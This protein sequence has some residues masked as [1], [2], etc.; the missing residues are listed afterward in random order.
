MCKSP[1]VRLASSKYRVELSRLLM[2][3]WI[4]AHGMAVYR[5]SNFQPWVPALASALPPV[6]KSPSDRLRRF[7]SGG[8][9]PHTWL[10]QVCNPRQPLGRVFSTMAPLA[11]A[12]RLHKRRCLGAA[13]SKLLLT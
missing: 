2:L 8:E 4:L 6:S 3:S 10:L 11:V 5:R 9:R 12:G 13:A 7:P 1:I